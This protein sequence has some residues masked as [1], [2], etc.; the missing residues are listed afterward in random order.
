M[1]N[2]KKAYCTYCSRD[3]RKDPRLLQAIERYDNDRIRAAHK[4]AL[5]D[6]VEFLILSGE[7]GVVSP[8]N[9]IPY[10]DHL[11]K[12]EEV[13]AL[14]ERVTVQLQEC[15]DRPDGQSA[16]SLSCATVRSTGREPS[17]ASAQ[18]TAHRSKGRSQDTAGSDLLE[19][20]GN[21]ALWNRFSH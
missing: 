5:N 7:Y 15:S 16:P 17:P 12:R 9:H 3:K 10:Y 20:G 4:Q 13:G 1:K 19:G 21:G 2:N 8:S 18:P 14:I 6:G 11:L